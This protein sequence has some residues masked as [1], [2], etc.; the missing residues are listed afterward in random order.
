MTPQGAAPND[1]KS[2]REALGRSRGGLT[3]KIHLAADQ[4]CRPITRLTSSGQHGD[5]PRFIPVLEQISIARRG[6]GRPR[7]RPGRA[8]G[9]RA[10]SSAANRAYLRR[11]GIKAVIPVK[12]DQKSHRRARGRSCGQPPAF[13]TGWHKQ[14]NTVE[15]C[16]SKLKQFRAWTSDPLGQTRALPGHQRRRI[17]PHL[18]TRPRHMI[19]ET[20][21]KPVRAPTCP[22]YP[23]HAR[24]SA[25]LAH[26]PSQEICVGPA[27]PGMTSLTRCT[28]AK[29]TCK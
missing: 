26:H 29:G 4:R 23:R 7:S 8:M 2:R 6:R 17:D 13:D 22:R 21:P 3:T 24:T 20:R 1:K 11:R 16:F 9:D 5:S 18:A 10:Y 27:A 15:R 12:E 25:A 19:Y 28:A 14:R